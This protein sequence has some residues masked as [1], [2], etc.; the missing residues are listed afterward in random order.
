[1]SVAPCRKNG[2]QPSSE[3]KVRRPELHDRKLVAGHE[4]VGCFYHARADQ[5]GG[6][7]IMVLE[8]LEDALDELRMVARM[9][10]WWH[11]GVDGGVW[12][13]CGR[14][15]INKDRGKTWM[16]VFTRFS[17]VNVS[18]FFAFRPT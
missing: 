12:R 5:A 11:R 13:F 7:D 17:C 1:M 4:L 3:V 2:K 6:E 10:A 16:R 9:R 14:W 8:M 18:G 15:M